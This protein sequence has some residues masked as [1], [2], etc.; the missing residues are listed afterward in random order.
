M[1][2]LAVLPSI[3]LFIIVWKGD[4]YEKE[5]PKLLLKLFL[6]GA[7]TTVS[8]SIIEILA[9][10]YILAFMDHQGM[11]Y[12]VIENFLIV[13]VAE[14]AGKYFVLKRASWK[15]PA[16]NYTFDGVVYAVTVSLGFATLENILYLFEGGIGTAVVRALFS[17]PGHAIDAVYMGYY[18]GLAKYA[19]AFKDMGLMKKNLKKA[20]FVPVILHGFYDFCLST[21]YGIFILIFLV[22]EVVITVLAAKKFLRLSKI[23]AVIP[24]DT[25]EKPA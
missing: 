6:F 5:P 20:F 17:V 1:L 25:D 16:F 19:A 4:R 2:Q 22:F 13:A 11:P 18:Y 10:D 12:I 3:I 24:E 14:E 23:E 15:D 21:E 8:A 9:G 7:L